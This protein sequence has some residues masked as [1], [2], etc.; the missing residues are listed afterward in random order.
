MTY[1]DELLSLRQNGR[2]RHRAVQ[3]KP[4]PTTT[5]V[6]AALRTGYAW[7]GRTPSMAALGGFLLYVLLS[8]Y[9]GELMSLPV[10]GLFNVGVLL[11]LLQFVGFFALATRG[12]RTDCR[13]DP[14]G[15]EL[16]EPVESYR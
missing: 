12:P 13:G 1:L 7:L 9:L 14:H 2:G 11:G 6:V 10:P 4:M 3:H 15:G 5:T 8:S 16:G